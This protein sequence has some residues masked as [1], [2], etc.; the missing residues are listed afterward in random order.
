MPLM[1]LFSPSRCCG[2]VA[3]GKAPVNTR[4]VDR[5][6]PYRG[7]SKRGE[8]REGRLKPL[9]GLRAALTPALVKSAYQAQNSVSQ[10]TI[11]G[12]HDLIEQNGRA[13]AAS[14]LSTAASLV[15][16]AASL[17]PTVDSL[18]SYVG[19]LLYS[20][21]SPVSAVDSAAYSAASLLSTAASL[22]SSAA[23]LLS[24]ASSLLSASPCGRQMSG[25][26]S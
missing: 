25:I 20:A 17:L 18:I 10:R 23:S 9:S 6:S 11:A 3:I 22:L 26:V 12:S 7:D 13:T 1:S 21:Y 4:Q 19:C 24:P 14:L 16:T 8:D 5:D 15:W 2:I